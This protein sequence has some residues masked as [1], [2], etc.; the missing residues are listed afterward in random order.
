MDQEEVL[1]KLKKDVRSLLLSSKVGLDPE[2]LRRDYGALLGHPMPLRSLGFRNVLDMIREMPDVASIQ[3]R[4]DGSLY[5]KT[6]SDET[7]RDLEELVSRQRT[8]PADRKRLQKKLGSFFSSRY[9]PGPNQLLPLPRRGRTPPALPAQLRGPVLLSQLES[10]FLLRFGLPLRLHSYGFYSTAEMLEAAS[11]LLA[12]SQ[13]RLGS[14]VSLRGQMLPRPL[15]VVNTPTPPKP[16]LGRVLKPQP[17]PP[18][19]KA[20]VTDSQVSEARP[21]AAETAPAPTESEGV[22]PERAGQAR[23]LSE[24]SSGGGSM[25]ELIENITENQEEPCFKDRVLKLEE[26]FRKQIQEN[27]VAGTISQTLKDKLQKVVA[28]CPGGVSVHDLP[29]KYQML[30]GEELPL[31]ESGFVSVTEMVGA[32][33]DVFHL[34]SVGERGV[35]HSW[36]V[37]IQEEEEGARTASESEGF[38]LPPVSYYFSSGASLWEAEEG[39]EVPALEPIEDQDTDRSAK[40]LETP[41]PS[42]QVHSCPLV[43]LDALQ[44][45]RLRPPTP[46]A[47]RELAAVFVEEVESPGN[48][49]IRFSDTEEARALEDMMI[50]MRRCYS[51][52]EVSKRYRLP[53]PLVRRGQAC[54]I[55]PKGMW[56]YRVVIHR[57]LSSSQVEVYYVDFGAIM[58]VQTSQLK[59]LKSCYS[60][61]PAQAVPASLVGIKPTN[62]VW[63]SEATE[64]FE[65]LCSDKKLVGA[66]DGYSGDVLLLY[67]CDTNTDQ[68]LYIHSALLEKGHATPCSLSVSAAL[69]PPVTPVSLYLGEG[70]VDLPEPEFT[71]QPGPAQ[72]EEEDE[73]VPGLELIENSEIVCPVQSSVLNSLL[74]EQT[75]AC[76]ELRWA[77]KDELPRVD[78]P[79]SPST[80]LP[81]LDLILTQTPPPHGATKDNNNVR[82]SRQEC[83]SICR[84]HA[85]ETL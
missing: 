6:V 40:P 15:C 64:Y 9:D 66:L 27:G 37:T 41:Y 10:C 67:L 69:R 31:L 38:E 22:E 78:P 42:I 39:E 60:V 72:Q 74:T 8:S 5:L 50:E 29:A 85:E 21:G 77:L 13:S 23:S 79:T 49:Y 43:P 14:M 11:D 25:P 44:C 81:P 59:L 3:Y 4:P 36:T 71:E 35:S 63:S 16:A 73:E 17:K 7:T 82:D 62:G 75:L 2:Q 48:F 51:Y 26:E 76:S 53:P 47:P 20:P 30:F 70:M 18:G 65:K 32:M 55:S 56:F 52:T 34:R 45:Q 58:A 68:D 61:L 46:H 84:E 33:T 24:P 28:Q 19:T 12:V 80:R 54:C 1:S 83:A 57:V